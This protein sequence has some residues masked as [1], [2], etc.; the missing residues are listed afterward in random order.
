MGQRV[1][2]YNRPRV[3]TEPGA[4][5]LTGQLPHPKVLPYKTG[6]VKTISIAVPARST[7]YAIPRK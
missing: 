7:A 2:K 3:V 1:I 4:N 5:A 6:P